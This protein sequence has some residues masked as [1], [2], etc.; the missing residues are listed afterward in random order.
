MNV[1]F[2]TVKPSTLSKYKG[3]LT[4]GAIGDALGWPVEFKRWEGIQSKFGK[5]GIQDFILNKK[6]VAEVTD[7]TQMSMFTADG[8]IKGALKKGTLKDMP[9]MSKVFESY[10]LWYQ[11][12]IGSKLQKGKGWIPE[13]TDLYI[14]RAPGNTCMSALSSEIAGS[15]RNPLNN[16]SGCGGVMRTAPAGL[17]Y[18]DDPELAFR[19]GAECAA[20]THGHPDGYLSAGV[21]SSMVAHLVNNKS[22]DEALNESM[23]TLRKYKNNE[24][25]NDLLATARYAAYTDADPR[26]IIGCLGEGWTGDEAIA[27]STYCAMKEPQNFEKAA[28]MAVNHN[29]DS[30]STGAILGNILGAH[31]G[32][33]GLPKK[34]AEKVEMKEELSKL[35]EDLYSKMDIHNAETRYPI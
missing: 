29:G 5:D 4:G 33:E 13:I 3:C 6:G 18:N 24:R 2:N 19:V 14:K 16:S 9:D 21:L 1:S 27:I 11:T 35:A 30:D 7:D 28:K 31:L 15:M 23:H 25:V 17:L 8:I 32:M 20:I 10:K 26:R 34:W 12:Q 22:L